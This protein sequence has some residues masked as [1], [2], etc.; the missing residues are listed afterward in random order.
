MTL[1]Q[2]VRRN[3][4]DRFLIRP[5]SIEADQYPLL[6]NISMICYTTIHNDKKIVVYHYYEDQIG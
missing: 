4:S 6:V 2:M 3:R 1:Y 5:V